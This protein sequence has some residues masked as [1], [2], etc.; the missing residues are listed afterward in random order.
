MRWKN[1]ESRTK[2]YQKKTRDTRNSIYLFLKAAIIILA[3]VALILIVAASFTNREFI[4][5]IWEKPNV[6]TNNP[7]FMI[8]T[9]CGTLVL[10]VGGKLLKKV[11]P[12]LVF[13]IFTILF[14]IAGIFMV[15][16]MPATMNPGT[17]QEFIYHIA[18]Q[19]NHGNF[20]A[21]RA[22]QYLGIYPFQ[23]GYVSFMRLLEC[24][25]MN[26]R[27]YYFVNLLLVILI[28]Y[29]LWKIVKLMAQ[30]NNVAQNFTIMLSYAFLPQ[31][32]YIVFVYGN[33]PGLCAMLGAVYFGL[34]TLI[35]GKKYRYSWI[36]CL[37]L[38]IIAYQLKSNYQIAAAALGIV[39]ILQ[40]IKQKRYWLIAMPFVIFAFF[41][42]SNRAI[43]AAYEAESGMK[44][45]QGL[46]MITYVTMGTTKNTEKRAPG[47]FDEYTTK[48][49]AKHDYEPAPTAK[50]AKKD[51]NKRMRYFAKH[52]DEMQKF[53]NDKFI[54]TWADPTFQGIWVSS[55][56]HKPKTEILQSVYYQ[57]YHKQGKYEISWYKKSG[58]KIAAWCNFLVVA[59]TFLALLYLVVTRTKIDWYSTFAIL[60]LMGGMLFHLIWETKSQYVFQYII[61]L[62]PVAA[63]MI[64]KDARTVSSNG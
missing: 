10:L 9:V 21:L 43:K 15:F 51:L 5:A 40:A 31:L 28:N 38:F 11:D 18:N 33:V 16:N 29:L 61:C 13:K 6:K 26:I 17:D 64:G 3:C 49:Y 50:A 42:G 12:R 62:I 22:S 36:G 45:Q 2:Q 59:I 1:M 58:K 57:N 41:L 30:E 32:L 4:G 19:M 37:L 23:L 14:T 39:Y 48:L 54:S 60:Y 56:H 35:D 63:M 52:P 34:R 27:F 25:S 44:V 20:H 46:P 24:F 53:F 7:G 55:W 8:G 47:W